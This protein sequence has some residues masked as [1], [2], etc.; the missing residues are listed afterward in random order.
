MK[1]KPNSYYELEAPCGRLRGLRRGDCLLFQAVPFA[2]AGRWEDPQP[3]ERWEGIRDA[4]GPGIHCCQYL[5]FYPRYTDPLNSFYYEQY[6]DKE[7]HQYS[8]A[9][10][11]NLNIWTLERGSKLPVAVFFHGGSFCTG[12]NT[13]GNIHEGAGYCRRGVILVS[14]NYRLNAFATGCDDTHKG[15][16]ALKDQIAALRWVRENISAFGGDPERVTV[17]GESAGAMSVQLLMYTPYARGLFR[18]AIMMS[19]G[20]DLTARGV[21]A[22]PKWSR[23]IWRCVMEQYGAR[24]L[25][26]LKQLPAKAVFDAWSQVCKSEVE[27]ARHWAYPMVDGDVIPAGAAQLRAAGAIADVPCI[28]GITGR[29]MIPDVLRKAAEDWA[30]EHRQHGRSPV[31]AYRMD[32]PAPGDAAGAYHGSDLWYAFG[33]LD[34]SWRPYTEEDWQLSDRMLDYFAGFIADGVPHAEGLPVWSAMTDGD[35]R[36]L[37]FDHEMPA[38]IQTEAE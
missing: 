24:S 23:E 30:D 29:D 19:G 20:G 31:Y 27:L 14:A 12:G 6:A 35:N 37:R 9:D 11:L 15:N 13:T 7:I 3:V 34:R 2:R 10:G 38:M 16:Y 5:Q 32:C 8:E 26:E 25:D 33:T 28:L 22:D 18:G 4:T 17:M 36:F 1:Q 21:P